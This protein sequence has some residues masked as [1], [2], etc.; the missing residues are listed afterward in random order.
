MA[1]SLFPLLTFF[2]PQ[3]FTMASKINEFA[4]F[5][6]R[7]GVHSLNEASKQHITL[8]IHLLAARGKQVRPD[9]DDMLLHMKMLKDAVKN[10]RKPTMVR[11]P[12]EYPDSPAEFKRTNPELY[13][14]AYV[15]GPPGQITFDQKEFDN[16]ARCLLK[17]STHH[18]AQGRRNHDTFATVSPPTSPTH[19]RGALP[20]A[21]PARLEARVTTMAG[22]SK[23]V[24]RIKTEL[25]DGR[26]CPALPCGGGLARAGAGSAESFRAVNSSTQ[27]SIEIISS[28]DEP[29]PVVKRERHHASMPAVV[30]P[31]TPAAAPPPKP[32][33]DARKTVDD[34]SSDLHQRMVDISS[35]RRAERARASG[36]RRSNGGAKARGSGNA[37]SSAGK[38]RAMKAA[39]ATKAMKV[40]KTK[41][42]PPGPYNPSFSVER[43]RFQAL[44]RT[45]RKGEKSI[46]FK[47]VGCG[48]QDAAI[49]KAEKWVQM[50]RRRHC[51]A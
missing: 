51:G 15:D 21:M 10:R 33:T 42:A 24:P 8:F 44:C 13:A 9:A 40:M 16:F 30:P 43:T 6:H 32:Q 41:V 23:F 39:N 22:P 27:T 25:D 47:F 12:W 37:K 26:N 49:S 31:S 38:P 14:A 3:G 28:D 45:G 50:M 5:L 48:G 11:G 1:V 36:G 4:G 17:R 35:A 34:M 18:L 2:Y 7:C 20:A 46:P 29:A 19:Q